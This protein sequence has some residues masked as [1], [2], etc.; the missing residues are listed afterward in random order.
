[1]QKVDLYSVQGAEI[2]REKSGGLIV[3]FSSQS[4]SDGQLI[5]L[6]SLKENFFLGF[7]SCI[8]YDCDLSTLTS[9]RVEGVGVFHSA[10]GDK[11]LKILSHLSGIRS[12]KLVDTSVT[13]KCISEIMQANGKIKIS[14]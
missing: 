6:N 10:F 1:M 3:G 13:A 4:I 8:F 7:Y 11:E 9:E 2:K 5:E 12:I 14:A